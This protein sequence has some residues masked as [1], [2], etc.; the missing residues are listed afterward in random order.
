MAQDPKYSKYILQAHIEENILKGKILLAGSE[1]LVSIEIDPENG[2]AST[3][4]FNEMAAAA[5]KLATYLSP[6]KLN[7]ITSSVS[8]EI[9]DS[10]YEQDD[11]QPSTEETDVLTKELSLVKI[12][13]FP[14]GFMLHYHAEKTF[15]GSEINVQLDTDFSIDDIAIYDE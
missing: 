9:T 2:G 3:G 13:V 7:E 5:K 14:E 12:T 4:D 11:H 10:A 8:L 1:K 6:K 15:P